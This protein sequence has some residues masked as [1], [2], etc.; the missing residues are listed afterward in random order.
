[1]QNTSPAPGRF[2]A[3][4]ARTS[5]V[6]STLGSLFVMGFVLAGPSSAAGTNP[7]G[8]A[9]SGLQ[10]DVTTYVTAAVALIALGVAAWLGIKYLVKAA[11]RA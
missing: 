4:A 3:L 8:S 5:V 6:G 11:G 10:A 1:M 2:K 7:V 9:I